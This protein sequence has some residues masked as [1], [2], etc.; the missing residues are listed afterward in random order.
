MFQHGQGTDIDYVQ[1]FEWFKKSAQQGFLETLSFLIFVLNI[2]TKNKTGNL[3][4]ANKIGNFYLN[5]IGTK[6]NETKAMH[7]FK[8][9]SAQATKTESV[10]ST[11]NFFVGIMTSSG[12]SFFF[13]HSKTFC[14][15]EF[16][17]K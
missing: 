14:Y 12:L 2:F 11:T 3:H 16:C 8:F 9:V 4:A 15:S 7:Y 17:F 10:S 1:S 13:F 6:K 5:G